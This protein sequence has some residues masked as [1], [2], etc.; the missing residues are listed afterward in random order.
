M[1]FNFTVTG[2]FDGE[3]IGEVLRLWTDKEELNE[4]TE[5]LLIRGFEAVAKR[6]ICAIKKIEKLP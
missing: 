4:E 6:I 1:Y 3:K 2:E 5:E